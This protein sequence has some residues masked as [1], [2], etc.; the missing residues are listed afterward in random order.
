VRAQVDE[1]LGV[2]RDL[3]EAAAE[4]DALA[5]AA[6]ALAAKVAA[7]QV[8]AST[9]EV[10][11]ALE[12]AR[13]RENAAKRPKPWRRDDTYRAAALEVEL[14][15]A[16]KQSGEGAA[17]AAA[18]REESE[19]LAEENA[20]LTEA[21]AAAG[22]AGSAAADAAKLKA[23]L[24]KSEETRAA[25]EADFQALMDSVE[26]LK[27]QQASGGSAPAAAPSSV[28]DA[29][30]VKLVS[31]LAAS[32][33]AACTLSPSRLTSL[34][35]ASPCLCRDLAASAAAARAAEADR[36][37]QEMRGPSVTRT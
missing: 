6:E 35:V 30:M 12:A 34:T 36:R 37:P 22:D 8:D 15:A 9:D 18:A 17:A 32:S 19:R 26:G 24:A 7:G 29:D 28:A 14:R 10:T 5:A 16:A 13:A 4:T 25:V 2:L 3:S 33:T 1:V 27:A 21:L 11:A 23:D 31:S 20:R